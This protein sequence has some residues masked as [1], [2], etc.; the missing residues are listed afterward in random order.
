M[1]AEFPSF[2]PLE[3]EHKDQIQAITSKFAPYSDFNFVS[4]FCWNTDNSTKVSILRG[5]LVVNFSD[6]L[7][8]E[9]IYSILGDKEIDR[10]LEALLD[11]TPV[12]KMVPEVVIS[13]IA[14]KQKFEIKEDETH[15][16]YIYSLDEH[17]NL[18]GRKFKEKRKKVTRF[19]KIHGDRFE[20]KQVRLDNPEV[21]KHIMEV[22]GHWGAS[23]QKN[24][25]DIK[26]EKAAINRLLIYAKQLDLVALKIYIDGKPAG[27]SIHEIIDDNQ[28]ICHFHKTIPKYNNLDLYLTHQAARDLVIRG[29][30]HVNWEQDLGLPGLRQS[31]QSYKPA[32]MLKKYTVGLR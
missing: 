21:Q 30:K 6:Y 25:Q 16:D 26:T 20:V 7:T 2:S 1:I 23:K 11:L 28:A 12:L 8:G 4:L 22:F 17:A 32:L 19:S 31:K 10:S 3:L 24:D 29:A 15:F 14:D 13:G 9:P 18:P 27:F 5:N